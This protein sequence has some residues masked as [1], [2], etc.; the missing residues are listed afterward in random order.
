MLIGKH[1]DHDEAGARRFFGAAWDLSVKLSEAL[2]AGLAR[3]VSAVREWLNNY[4]LKEAPM[5]T[6]D[7]QEAT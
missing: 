6:K 7:V 5:P 4:G 3:T 2:A 1:D